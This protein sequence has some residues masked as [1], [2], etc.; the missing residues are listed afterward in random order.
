[1]RAGKLANRA[2]QRVAQHLALLGREPV[3]VEHFEQGD[4]VEGDDQREHLPCI[5]AAL[6][7][8][9]IA[10]REEIPHGTGQMRIQRRGGQ[11]V[12]QQQAAVF[13]HVEGQLRQLGHRR[14]QRLRGIVRLAR[15]TC[16]LRPQVQHVQFADHPL[17][18]R[19][20]Q[21]V[22]RFEMVD[23]ARFRDLRGSGHGFNGQVLDTL[24]GHEPAAASRR[25][26]RELV[27]PARRSEV[28]MVHLLGIE[29]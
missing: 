19:S 9:C 17:D 7:N 11:Q 15:I 25:R 5:G 10:A 16:L 21:V 8:P 26:S 3:Q 23:K 12:G 27:R 18:Q 29:T 6:R 13:R 14:L 24:A 20:Q 28:D 1:M 2:F 22:A 4:A